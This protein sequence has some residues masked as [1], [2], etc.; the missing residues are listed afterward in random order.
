MLNDAND[1]HWFIKLEHHTFIAA[2]LPNKILT[3]L[4]QDVIAK[5]AAESTE[6]LEKLH[7][8]ETELAEQSVC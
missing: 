2:L 8:L 7:T 1:R 5:K 6:T 4:P 3:L